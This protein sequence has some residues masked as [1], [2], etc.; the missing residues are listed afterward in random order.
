MCVL[1]MQ[2]SSKGVGPELS[3]LGEAAIRE[4]GLVPVGLDASTDK[5][6][7]LERPLEECH[8]AFEEQTESVALA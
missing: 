2:P 1:C 3:W 7:Q 6:A 8:G 4:G 5:G